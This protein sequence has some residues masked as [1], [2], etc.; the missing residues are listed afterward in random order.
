MQEVTFEYQNMTDD[1]ISKI[2]VDLV[3]LSE[4]IQISDTS[5]TESDGNG[6]LQAQSIQKTFSEVEGFVFD[7]LVMELLGSAVDIRSNEMMV[8]STSKAGKSQG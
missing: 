8:V 6:N 4:E 1:N 7:N 5:F 2:T 3:P